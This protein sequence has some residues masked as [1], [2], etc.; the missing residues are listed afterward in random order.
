[1]L[2]VL[3][4]VGL[5]AYGEYIGQGGFYADDWAHA[6]FYEFAD[7]PRYWAL[8]DELSDVLGGR[9]LMT[10]LMPLPQVFFGADAESHLV[11]ALVIAI[12]LSLCFYLALRALAMPPAHAA[13][14]A[15]LVLLFPR[16]DSIRLWATGSVLSIAVILFLLGFVLAIRGLEHGGRRGILLHA[17]ADLLYLLS[18]LAYEA[19]AG[20]AAVAGVLYLRRAPRRRAVRSWIAD[21]AVVFAAL[22]YS[23]IATS[24]TREVGSLGE[25]VSDLAPFLRQ[26]VLVLP[27]ALVPVGASARPFLAI[28]LLAAATVVALSVLRLRRGPEPALRWWLDWIIGATVAIAAGY[29]MFLG[30]TLHPEDSGINNRIQLVAGMAFVVLAYAIV[31]TACHLLL[32]SARSAA[33]GTVLVAI[34]IAVGYGIGLNDDQARWE[35]AADE[36]ERVLRVVDRSV[37]SLPRRSTLIAFGYPKDT[38]PGIPVFSQGFDLSAGLRLHSGDPTLRGVPVYEGIAVRC[39]GDSMSFSG[40]GEYGSFELGYEMA[41]FMDVEGEEGGPLRTRSDCEARLG[42]GFVAP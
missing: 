34:A 18:V 15:V 16:S 20:V 22:V 19:T 31:A 10:L 27:D 41:Y 5:L 1:M 28:V 23:L 25:R 3:T 37:G 39:E 8:V 33:I 21:V 38:G 13:A 24:G 42:R 32:R 14:I 12:T 9:P 30:S 6:S 2:A 7:P 35:R 40:P 26:S 17:G 11:L 29:V 36:Q 4:A